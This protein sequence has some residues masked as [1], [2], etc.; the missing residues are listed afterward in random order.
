MLSATGHARELHDAALDGVHQREVAHRP[1]EQRALGVAGAAEEERGRRQV[2]DAPQAELPVHGFE[3]VDP[4]PCGLAVLLGLPAVVAHELL[5][6]VLAGLLAVAVMRLVVERHDA[7]H[8]H[9]F[10]HDPL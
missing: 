8:A 10:G 5:F 6:V 7:A 2:D 1:R 3:P 9:Q 4:E